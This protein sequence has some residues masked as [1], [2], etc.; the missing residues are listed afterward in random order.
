MS[1]KPDRALTCVPDIWALF[2]ACRQP[3]ALFP[4]PLA[5]GTGFSLSSSPT[6]DPEL[7]GFGKFLSV[8]PN[9]LGP[10]ACPPGRGQCCSRV[11]ENDWALPPV[12]PKFGHCPRVF[13]R[14][15]RCPRTLGTAPGVSLTFSS[16]RRRRRAL[17]RCLGSSCAHGRSFQPPASSFAVSS[18]PPPRPMPASPPDPPPSRRGWRSPREAAGA[19]RTRRRSLLRA[20]GSAAALAGTWRPETCAALVCSLQRSQSWGRRLGGPE[21]G[22][23]GRWVGST[24][25]RGAPRSGGA[26]PPSPRVRGLGEARAERGRSD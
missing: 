24:P 17:A 23:A 7:L 3:S 18:P 16:V 5:A 9:T 11:Q 6:K 14:T 25:R 15:G 2:P 21:A 20:C 1:R 22:R 8:F 12:S 13:Q 26:A 19:T 10:A 4:T